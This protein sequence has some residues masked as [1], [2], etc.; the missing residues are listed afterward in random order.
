M[1]PPVAAQP[2]ELST[3]LDRTDRER[4]L[5]AVEQW[6][7]E[8][9]FLLTSEDAK[10]EIISAKNSDGSCSPERP[11]SSDNSTRARKRSSSP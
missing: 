8:T 7:S 11:D 3:P 10:I 1:N 6:G 5:A 9:V 4:W 2:I